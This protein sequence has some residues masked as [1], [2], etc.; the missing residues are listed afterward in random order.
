MERSYDCPV[1]WAHVTSSQLRTKYVL[2]TNPVKKDTKTKCRRAPGAKMTRGTV[3]CYGRNVHCLLVFPSVFSPAEGTLAARASSQGIGG[4][5]GLKPTPRLVVLFFFF[6]DWN[7]NACRWTPEPQIHTFILNNPF[8]TCHGGH[9]ARWSDRDLKRRWKEQKSFT[10]SLFEQLWNRVDLRQIKP[11]MSLNS[12]R[13]PIWTTN[14]P[15]AFWRDEASMGSLV[16]EVKYN[17]QSQFIMLTFD[18]EMNPVSSWRGESAPTHNQM[19]YK[20][21]HWPLTPFTKRTHTHTP[22]ELWVQSSC[23][24]LIS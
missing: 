4:V 19:F 14:V 3:K 10:L 13:S 15:N 2:W 21:S 24:F 9:T 7:L 1:L 20:N 11:G 16:P 17:L 6:Q 5:K 23:V 8:A 18:L 22:A 12:C